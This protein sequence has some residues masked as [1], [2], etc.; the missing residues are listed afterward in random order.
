MD[1]RNE[2]YEDDGFDFDSSSENNKKESIGSNTL[3]LN[4]HN[5]RKAALLNSYNPEKVDSS[6]YTSFKGKNAGFADKKKKEI[7]HPDAH[8]AKV[9]LSKEM[10]KK[11][12]NHDIGEAAEW[13]FKSLNRANIGSDD[14]DFDDDN[15]KNEDDEFDAIL[16][17]QDDSQ[18]VQMPQEKWINPTLNNQIKT[19]KP[20]YQKNG[21]IT[22]GLAKKAAEL[23][24]KD[25]GENHNQIDKPI[26]QAND[27][28]EH[29][30]GKTRKSG[31]KKKKKR[32]SIARRLSDDEWDLA[33]KNLPEK[34]EI[35]HNQISSVRPSAY[36]ENHFLS[37]DYSEMYNQHEIDSRPKSML[38]T[39][40][41]CLLPKLEESQEICRKNLVVL[42]LI[43]FEEKNSN[44]QS[45]LQSIYFQLTN[46]KEVPH[47]GAHWKDIGF[48]GNSPATDIRGTG[49]LGLLMAISFGDKHPLWS[50]SLCISL[51][52]LR[53][54]YLCSLFTLTSFILPILKSREDQSLFKSDPSYFNQALKI[55]SAKTLVFLGTLVSL[56]ESITIYGERLEKMKR[57]NALPRNA[58]FGLN[59][60]LQA[61]DKAKDEED[62]LQA[63]SKSGIKQIQW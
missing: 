8:V 58:Q 30:I 50:K 25:S 60:M 13:Q 29:K 27:L 38:F 59:W 52:S 41:P 63:I 62:L 32:K 26:V 34:G 24:E 7:R 57:L 55:F 19:F 47:I 37:Q 28:N 22:N 40:F 10:K 18:N 46:I 61:Y 35:L 48:Q 1:Q 49:I 14:E 53:I 17:N 5:E 31:K 20:K 2:G 44:H 6:K 42:S 11:V 16:N 51:Q 21:L 15:K 3:N 4:D 23:K 45:I 36:F 43:G 39:I 9:K 33:N 12:E 56:N 54:P